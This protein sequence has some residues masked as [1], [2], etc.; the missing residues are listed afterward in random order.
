ML[1]F[2]ICLLRL[3]L[4]RYILFGFMTVFDVLSFNKELIRR[5]DLLGLKLGD[6][7][8][9]N[10]YSEYEDMYKA[11]EKMTYIVSFLSVKYGISERKVYMIVKLFKSDCKM[12]A[13]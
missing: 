9:I 4:Q 7:K 8:Y 2:F 12:L 11:G 1:P 6:Y 5:L 10:L 3:A 13:V